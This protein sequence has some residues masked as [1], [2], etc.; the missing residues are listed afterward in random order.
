MRKKFSRS[1]SL[2]GKPP[3]SKNRNGFLLKRQSRRDQFNF[4]GSAGNLTSAVVAAS[5]KTQKRWIKVIIPEIGLNKN[6]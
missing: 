6:C 5:A 4:A 1:E 3:E 2:T